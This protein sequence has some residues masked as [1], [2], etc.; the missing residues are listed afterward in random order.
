MKL[1]LFLKGNDR[2]HSPKMVYK[3]NSITGIQIENI[4]LVV[5]QIVVIKI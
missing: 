4:A 5:G 1:L 3:F 2:S